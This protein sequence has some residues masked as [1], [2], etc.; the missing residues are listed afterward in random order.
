MHFRIQVYRLYQYLQLYHVYYI[1]SETVT[2]RFSYTYYVGS[3]DSIA[4]PDK[5]RYVKRNI[6]HVSMEYFRIFG[7]TGSRASNIQLFQTTLTEKKGKKLLPFAIL[8]SWRMSFLLFMHDIPC[9]IIQ[10]RV[11]LSKRDLFSFQSDFSIAL[12]FVCI[13]IG[14]MKY[15]YGLHVQLTWCASFF[16]PQKKMLYELKFSNWMKFEASQQSSKML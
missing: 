13:T 3:K 12:V 5:V 1:P 2:I 4:K 6:F 7:R 11:N 8:N 10:N 14:W 15:K 16:P 9:N